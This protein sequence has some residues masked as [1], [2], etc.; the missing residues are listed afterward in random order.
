M[1]FDLRGNRLGRGKGFYDRLLEKISGVKCG[2]CLDFQ[3]VEN[4]PMEPHDATMRFMVTPT[5]CVSVKK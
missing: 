2:V 1:A 5:R 4:V 3:I